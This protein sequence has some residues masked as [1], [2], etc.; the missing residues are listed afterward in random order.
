MVHR[1]DFETFCTLAADHTMVPVY[2][3]LLS[4]TLTPVSA[5]MRM[6]PGS[7]SFLFESVHGGEKVGRYS[8]FGGSPFFKMFAFDR[9]VTVED[10][11]QTKTYHADDPLAE[12]DKLLAE[13]RAPQVPGLPRFV[14]GAVGYA[15]YDAVRYFEHLPNAPTDDRKLP[16]MAF[17]LY[18]Q[19]VVFDHISKVILVVVMVRVDS[20]DL[21]GCYE[22]GCQRVDAIADQLAAGT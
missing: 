17:G 20:A 13:Y 1:P 11:G 6:E 7:W 5:F 21:A 14:G 8:F 18:D 22:R 19:M 12:L 16:D 10:D 4:D 3:R 15:G 2:R 9:Q